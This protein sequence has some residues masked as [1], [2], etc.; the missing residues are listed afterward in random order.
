MWKFLVLKW[1][2]FQYMTKFLKNVTF[3]VIVTRLSW[4]ALSK[5]YEFLIKVF[6]IQFNIY[7]I[8]EFY[9]HTF[10]ATKMAFLSI[11]CK[12]F[13]N[14]ILIVKFTKPVSN[15]LWKGCYFLTNFLK[16]QNKFFKM[17]ITCL[18]YLTVFNLESSDTK[19]FYDVKFSNTKLAMLSNIM[20]YLKKWPLL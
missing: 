10:S 7:Y 13:K 14:S 18:L 5:N 19:M 6:K 2:L 17:S 3:I 15:T 9:D 20:Q 1:R 11:Q 16:S 12:I 8:A 4:K